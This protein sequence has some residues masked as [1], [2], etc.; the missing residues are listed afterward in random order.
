[1]EALPTGVVGQGDEFGELLG[2]RIQRQNESEGA[3]K[4]N[5]RSHID[6]DCIGNADSG[7]AW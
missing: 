7:N 2:R 3:D 6:R 1:M 5:A 4:T